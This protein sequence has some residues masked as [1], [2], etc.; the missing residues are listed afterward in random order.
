MYL[1]S[2]FYSWNLKRDMFKG[3]Y[4]KWHRYILKIFEK[5]RVFKSYFSLHWVQFSLLQIKVI[6]VILV[7]IYFSFLLFILGDRLVETWVLFWKVCKTVSW[8]KFW[9]YYNL[10]CAF[11]YIHFV[12]SNKIQHY[13][14]NRHVLV[15]NLCIMLIDFKLK[16]CFILYNIFHQACILLNCKQIVICLDQDG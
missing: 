13:Q 10:M 16:T 14:N 3:F 1:K 7:S 6:C 5:K 2:L 11:T 9:I 8:C 4:Q 12:W 15:W